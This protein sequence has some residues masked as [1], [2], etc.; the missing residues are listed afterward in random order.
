MRIRRLATASE[1]ID[2]CGGTVATANLI[3]STLPHVKKQHVSNWR[4]DG[5]LPHDTFLLFAAELKRRNARAPAELWG[6]IDP[7]VAKAS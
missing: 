7:A 4:R 3:A 6:I 1:V 2:F 5:R